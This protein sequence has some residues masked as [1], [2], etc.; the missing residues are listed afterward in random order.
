MCGEYEKMR[1]KE[2]DEKEEQS[3]TRMQCYSRLSFPFFINLTLTQP[4]PQQQA[5]LR[6]Q[7]EQFKSLYESAQKEKESVSV[8]RTMRGW[9]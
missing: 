8:L 3:H 4:P 2:R 5:Q 7:Y 1:Y 6:G 9:R